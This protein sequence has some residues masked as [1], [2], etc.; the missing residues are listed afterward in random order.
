V[1]N[2]QAIKSVEKISE[3]YW[4]AAR[5]VKL[6]GVTCAKGHTKSASNDSKV[7]FKKSIASCV[8]STLCKH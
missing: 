3:N 1:V 4:G 7:V 2:L 6:F 8:N 5:K